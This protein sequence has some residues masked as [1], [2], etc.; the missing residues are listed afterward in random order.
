MQEKLRVAEAAGLVQV[1]VGREAEK[2]VA[3]VRLGVEEAQ[4]GVEAA[5]PAV[6]AELEGVGEPQAELAAEAPAGVEEQAAR[7]VQGEQ[8]AEAP[9]GVQEQAGREVAGLRAEPVRAGEGLA[10]E[11]LA[12]VQEPAGAREV[13]EVDLEQGRVAVEGRAEEQGLSLEDG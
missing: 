13:E 12:G 9:A 3:E 6:V 5:G 2:V 1:V 10:A 8:G 7:E 4:E 11:V